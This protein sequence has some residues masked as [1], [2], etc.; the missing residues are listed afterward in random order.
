VGGEY[1]AGRARARLMITGERSS[2]QSGRWV[3]CR[4]AR[5]SQRT[6]LTPTRG[7]RGPRGSV[8]A[9]GVCRCDDIGGG[10][11][12][13][14]IT[15]VRSALRREGANPSGR[16]RLRELGEEPAGCCSCSCAARRSEGDPRVRDEES[17]G[18]RVLSI[19][20]SSTVWAGADVPDPGELRVG[21]L[22]ERADPGS[23]RLR[24]WT[25][26]SR[27]LA[28]WAGLEGLSQ[29][30]RFAARSGRSVVL[31]TSSAI[32]DQGVVRNC[33]GVARAKR[34]DRLKPSVCPA[35]PSRGVVAGSCDRR[36]WLGVLVRSSKWG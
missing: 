11:R 30:A 29:A 16:P 6:R 24:R 19:G 34:R 4:G 5:A 22:Y 15:A 13:A 35:L 28:F 9:P 2:V 14:A 1:R 18:R 36:E 27:P 21:R 3:A 31:S 32:S 20:A 12:D 8:L 7:T 33:Q 17:P 25:V 26:D 10:G 23:G